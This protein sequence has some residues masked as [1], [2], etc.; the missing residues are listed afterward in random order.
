MVSILVQ[1]TTDEQHPVYFDSLFDSIVEAELWELVG[2][3]QTP[4]FCN[5]FWAT[6]RYV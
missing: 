1:C 2:N 6:A 4:Y 3:Q 5:V